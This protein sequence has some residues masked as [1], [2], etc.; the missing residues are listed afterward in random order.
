MDETFLRRIDRE[1]SRWYDKSGRHAQAAI[2][3][4]LGERLVG[5]ALVESLKYISSLYKNVSVNIE[6]QGADKLG[7]P[8]YFVNIIIIID[9]SIEMIID[10]EVKNRDPEDLVN[11]AQ[12]ED[13]IIRKK[14]REHARKILVSPEI[15]LQSPELLEESGISHVTWGKYQVKERHGESYEIALRELITKFNSLFINEIEGHIYSYRKPIRHYTSLTLLRKR[16]IEEIIELSNKTECCRVAP[17][18]I[19]HSKHLLNDLPGYI[20]K[21]IRNCFT[22]EVICYE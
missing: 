12:I 13:R 18:P 8:D 20:I 14:W 11:R 22:N 10:I 19:T 21:T 9:T 17:N 4:L 7:N 16:R 5:H 15:L 3:G 6:Y 2:L 1:L